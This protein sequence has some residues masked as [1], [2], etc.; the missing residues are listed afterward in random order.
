MVTLPGAVR[1]VCR[2]GSFF[3]IASAGSQSVKGKD[4]TL[5]EVIFKEDSLLGRSQEDEVCY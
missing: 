1:G 2:W 4:L 3:R 5:R